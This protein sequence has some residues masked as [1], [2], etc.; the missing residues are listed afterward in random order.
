MLIVRQLAT[1][2]AGEIFSTQNWGFGATPAIYLGDQVADQNGGSLLIWQ[3]SQVK[4][5]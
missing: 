1:R 5:L 3:L 2:D 4:S